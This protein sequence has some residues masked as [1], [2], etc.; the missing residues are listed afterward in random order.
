[1]ELLALVVDGLAAEQ[2]GHDGVG[3]VAGRNGPDAQAYRRKRQVLA[4]TIS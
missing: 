1:V 3:S 4:R 2:V